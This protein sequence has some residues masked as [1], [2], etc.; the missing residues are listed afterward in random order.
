MS[1]ATGRRSRSAQTK[2][3]RKPNRAEWRM[4]REVFVADTDAEA[5]RLSVG[6]HMGRM[7]REYFLPLL[8]EFEFLQFLKHDPTSPTATSR[9][10]IARITAG[11]SAHR[12]RWPRR[13]RA[14]TTRSV[15]SAISWCL[16]ST[17]SSTPEAWHRSLQLLAQEVLPRVRQLSP[18]A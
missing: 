14:S 12:R 7:M 2:T 5:M 4:V 13:L 8:K 17:M 9:L 1:A 3:G 15:A 18:A 10:N 6:L 16:A 11:S